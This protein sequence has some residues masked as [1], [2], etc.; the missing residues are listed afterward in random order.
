MLVLACWCGPPR[1]EQPL[2][3]LGAGVVP[4]TFP[5]Y[6]GSDR[7]RPYLLPLPYIIYRGERLRIGRGGIRGLLFDSDRV[8]LDISLGGAIPVKSDDDGARAGM[9]DLDP[10]FELG[11]ALNIDLP[12]WSTQ[13]R[14]QLRL[15]LRA[16]FT[17]D[18]QSLDANGALF[19]PQLDVDFR[20]AAQGWNKSI[21]IGALWA[22]DD[23]HDYY[24]S[25]EPGFAT[26]A[27]PS[28]AV[29]G[30]YSGTTLIFTASKRYAKTWVGAFLRYDNLAGTRFQD[31]PLVESDHSIMAG[32][33]VSY[34]FAR[35]RRLVSDIDDKE[36]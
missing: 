18:L 3:E 10:A 28:Y 13:T 20:A 17:T 26:P 14:W 29:R 36:F 16:V 32:I 27:R 25:V 19:H 35:S 8:E 5:D 34:L 12:S 7:Q 23:Y 11:P 1:A 2:W 15:P 31:S 4:S 6:R 24:Y 33:A 21:S 9:P 30:G 22:S